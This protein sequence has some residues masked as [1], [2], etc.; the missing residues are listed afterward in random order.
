MLLVFFRERVYRFTASAALVLA[1][2]LL[3]Y[4][5]GMHTTTEPT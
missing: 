2:N 5:L 3:G 4:A 1:I